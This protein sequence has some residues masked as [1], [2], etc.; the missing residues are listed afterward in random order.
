MSDP[1]S[2]PTEAAVAPE[3]PAGGGSM[4]RV[5]VAALGT[6]LLATFASFAAAIVVGPQLRDGP[7]GF[8]LPL[9]ALW[10]A[11]GLAGALVAS[12]GRSSAVL[13]G[14]ASAVATWALAAGPVLLLRLQAPMLAAEGDIE[15][16]KPLLASVG[17]RVF[18][19]GAAASILVPAL[20][21]G[22]GLVAAL[23]VRAPTTRITGMA[24]LIPSVSLLS[25]LS[26]GDV[27]L[28]TAMFDDLGRSLAR[29]GP[30][31]TAAD[32][33]IL[34]TCL[35]SAAPIVAL[36]ALLPGRLTHPLWSFSV[37]PRLFYVGL[38]GLAVLTLLCAGWTHFAAFARPLPFGGAVVL[39]GAIV[40]GFALAATREL[41]ELEVLTVGHIVSGAML[42]G[43]GWMV[44][45]GIFVPG[46]SLTAVSLPVLDRENR[47]LLD[48]DA[49]PRTAMIA[50]AIFSG[51]GFVIAS[52]VALV[53]GFVFAT[54]EEARRE[55]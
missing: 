41:P 19:T 18:S 29:Y 14:S 30:Y 13:A 40:A 25:L 36:G 3:A 21:A 48:A 27:L 20:G 50:H 45:H 47:A 22:L 5:L 51:V 11:P 10:I 6:A 17:A 55:G 15:A 42:A 38:A 53:A 46:V 28:S 32:S 4:F 1:F 34:A 26:L 12:Q 43:I 8:V 33:A 9:L 24:V 23:A 7:V 52:I 37:G 54:V 49:L 44:V 16:V 31:T 35:L 39:V 2:S